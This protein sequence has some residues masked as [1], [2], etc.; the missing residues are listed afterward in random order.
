MQIFHKMITAIDVGKNMISGARARKFRGIIS[1]PVFVS[2]RNEDNVVEHLKTLR[3]KLKPD[4]E[5]IVVTNFPMEDILFNTLEIPRELRKSEFR[6]YVTA[7]MSRILNL[8]S[9]EISLDFVRNPIGKALVMVTK[10][11][12]LNEWINNIAAAGF[13]LPDVVIPDAFKYMQLLRIP[14]PETCVLVL[15][16]RDYS[17]VVVSVSG[18]PVG[19]RVFS[20][21][22]N[23]VVS[24]ISEETGLSEAEILQELS[25]KE[26]IDVRGIFESIT[27]DF[28]Y[29]VER[30]IIFMLSSALPG[31]SIRDVARFCI[32]CDPVEFIPH[33]AKLFG[34]IETMQGKIEPLNP[35]INV[36]DSPLGTVGLLM[37]GGEEFGKNKLIQI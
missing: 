3:E 36:K 35:I 12:R 37:R 5:D 25:K 33:Y 1:N 6:A 28:P 13:P 20:Y 22:L 17:V 11:R 2:I 14:G 19:I 26:S 15:L 30:E 10:T 23:E 21:S 9:A 27:A 16:T 32:F 31:S 24:I 8:S 34:M 4:I 7:E 18:S 29:S